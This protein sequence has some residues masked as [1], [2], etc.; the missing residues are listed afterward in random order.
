[1]DAPPSGIANA[2]SP[3]PT[4]A[5][6]LAA[7]GVASYTWTGAGLLKSA[8][9]T[10]YTYDGDGK[11]VKNSAG[12]TFWTAPS[13]DP[14]SD[15]PGSAAGNE[16][17]YFAGRRIAWVD[18]S[19]TVRYTWGDHLGST[20]LATDGS[21]NVCYDADFYP[22]GGERTPYVSSCAPAYKFAG[23]KSDAESGNDYTL[24][25]Y[26]PPNLGRWMS[27]DPLAGDVSNP[28]SLNRYAYVLNKPTTFTD[29]LGLEIWDGSN[30][31]R[32]AWYSA[33]HAECA[34][35][36]PCIAP[37]EWRNPIMPFPAPGGHRGGGS[38]GGGGTS[39]SGGTTGEGGYSGVGPT[40]GPNAFQSGADVAYPPYII[41]LTVWGWPYIVACAANPTCVAVAAG[42]TVGVAV[43][44][45]A[46]ALENYIHEVRGKSDPVTVMKPVNPGRDAS[47]NCNPCPGSPP[48]WDVPGGGHGS[49]SGTH[50]HWIEWNQDPATCTCY[51]KRKSGPSAP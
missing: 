40:V 47:G 45:G 8:G 7:D 13:G 18:A 35:P 39:Q 22:F 44:Y 17:I 27:P 24:N 23:M 32:D 28:Q 20:R 25:R 15:T 34:D 38:S 46:V 31:C 37:G 4:P 30:D 3:L 1:M 19:G 9:S 11:R 43:G 49:T 10:T 29:P 33:S 50:W 12:T 51:P 5:G 41:Q 36:G 6:H 14:L 2:A 16:Y 48:A 21:G 42:V 26:Y